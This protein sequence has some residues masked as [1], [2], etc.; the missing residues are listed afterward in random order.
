MFFLQKKDVISVGCLLGCRLSELKLQCEVKAFVSDLH[1]MQMYA[2]H[3]FNFFPFWTLSIAEVNEIGPCMLL[4]LK[5]IECV[6][7]LSPHKP[8]SF[9]LFSHTS[10]V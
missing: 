1:E 2:K 9:L 7:T 6:G 8:H 3:Q 4:Q 10:I 5:I